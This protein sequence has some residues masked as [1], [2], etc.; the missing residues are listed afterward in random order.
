MLIREAFQSKDIEALKV[1]Y[2]EIEGYGGPE[3]TEQEKI[4]EHAMFQSFLSLGFMMEDDEDDFSLDEL[5]KIE[6]ELVMSEE[7]ESNEEESDIE[8]EEK[9]DHNQL[10]LENQLDLNYESEN[11]GI[12]I[13]SKNITF[14]RIPPVAKVLSF[15]EYL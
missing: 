5:D 10:D 12:D 7:E 13:K 1:I 3:M 8:E 14:L 6:D 4:A 15:A 2:K 11:V 9:E